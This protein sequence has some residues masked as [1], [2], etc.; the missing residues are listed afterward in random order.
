MT[1][2]VMLEAKGEG[3]AWAF[4]DGKLRYNHDGVREMI[5]QMHNQS[6]AA[7][8]ANRSVEWHVAEKP[9]ADYLA[10]VAMSLRHKNVTVVN[11]PPIYSLEAR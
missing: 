1:D 8:L 11:T 2:G 10:G 9:L 4:K 6:E 5:E 3:F 7:A